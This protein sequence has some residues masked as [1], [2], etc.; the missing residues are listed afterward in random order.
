MNSNC[1][2]DLNGFSN[3]LGLPIEDIADLYYDLIAEINSEISKAKTFL[4]EKNLNELKQINHNIKGITAN[5]R[6]LDLYEETIKISNAL[7]KGD[8]KNIEFL[9]NNFFAIS[10]NAVKEV[11]KYFKQNCPIIE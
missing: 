5:Y 7:T 2:Y 10:D 4:Y 9:F 6:I 8:F 3:D 1:R 11:A